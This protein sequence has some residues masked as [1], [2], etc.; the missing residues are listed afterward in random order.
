MVHGLFEG[1]QIIYLIYLT[2][3]FNP[4]LVAVLSNIIFGT[5]TKKC[6]CFGTSNCGKH[7]T[8]NLLY[9]GKN[10]V[11]Y[12]DVCKDNTVRLKRISNSGFT[13]CHFSFI[14]WVV[15]GV[16]LAILYETFGLLL[17]CSLAYREKCCKFA[18]LI[19]VSASS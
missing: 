3:L 15:I 16:G 11:S 19:T 9:R 8:L 17:F 12:C 2:N 10:T 18:N 6:S 1:K 13:Y 7:K 14:V 5:A 4:Y